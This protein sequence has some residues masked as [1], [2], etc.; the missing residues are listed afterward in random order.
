[1]REGLWS[2]EPVRPLPLAW[3]RNLLQLAIVIGEGFV[4]DQLLLR[5]YRLTYL[6]LLSL[7]PLL[8]LAVTLVDLVGGS[9]QVLRWIVGQVAAGSPEAVDYILRYVQQ[10]DFRALGGVSSLIL[11]AT[12]ILAVGGAEQALNAIWGVKKQRPWVR[13]VSDY[14]AVLIVAPLLL[15]VAIP[16][17][18][19]LESQWVVQ[20]L[21][22][23]PGFADLYRLGLAQAPTL[24]VVAAF[25]FLYW[26]LPNT[27]VRARAAAVGGLVAG[28]LFSAAQVLY[29][30]FSVGAARYGAIFGTF[31]FLPLLMV[32]IYLSWAIVLFG[33]EVAYAVQTL[34]RYRR[35]VRGQPAGPAA[36]EAI[37]LAMALQVARAFRD[38]RAPWDTEALSDALD[39][40]L[41]TVRGVMGELESAG[42]VRACAG[43]GEEGGYLLAR[44][45]ER[46]RVADVLAALRGPREARLPGG[47]VARAVSEVFG[48][49]DREALRV[50]EAR[51][52]HDLL[53]DVPAALEPARAG[54]AARA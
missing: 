4:R 18:T 46:I 25:S 53:E 6:T 2:R 15:G 31:A 16:L 49:I 41:R 27:E 35:E 39:V 21:L 45:A 17:R 13:R 24:L 11:L 37:G 51:T 26:F 9:E 19:T 23:V 43:E 8:A 54:A 42:V 47:E 14:L 36:R 38:G 1:V 30:G 10:F 33:A 29:L 34:P 50:A 32:W 40:P 28:V 12:T 44:P 5:A 7:V 48:A 20:R 22:E 3:A 52:L